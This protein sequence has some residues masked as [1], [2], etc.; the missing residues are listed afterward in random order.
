M[1]PPGGRGIGVRRRGARVGRP[2][3]R[4]VLRPVG[5]VLRGRQNFRPRRRVRLAR[6]RRR[7]GGRGGGYAGTALTAVALPSPHVLNVGLSAEPWPLGSYQFADSEL[8]LSFDPGR[9]TAE[10]LAS[11][12]LP[13]S[14]DGGAGGGDLRGAM[15]RRFAGYFRDSVGGG[16]FDVRGVDLHGGKISGGGTAAATAGSSTTPPLLRGGG[17]RRR[18]G[19]GEDA[20]VA[21]TYSYTTRGMYHPPPREELG[22]IVSDSIN[23]DPV[24]I[25]K[26][27]GDR[28]GGEGEDDGDGPPMPPVFA[29]AESAVS[30]HLTM[31][32]PPLPA[33][34]E[35]EVGS[36][37]E[38]WA[39][40]PIILISASIASLVGL[41]LFRRMLGRRRRA[42]TV[43]DDPFDPFESYFDKGAG[44]AAFAAP[45]RD[46]VY[47]KG[48]AARGKRD[49]YDGGGGEPQG[50]RKNNPKMDGARSLNS[51]ER[52]SSSSSTSG[53]LKSKKKRRLQGGGGEDDVVADITAPPTAAP[54]PPRLPDAP[55]AAQRYQ[56]QLAWEA[57]VDRGQVQPGVRPR[58]SVRDRSRLPKDGGRSGGGGPSSSSSSRRLGGGGVADR[59]HGPDASSTRRSRRLEAE[60]S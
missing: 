8:T 23:A 7:I 47:D 2:R 25:V 35:Y 40:I 45:S 33:I 19:L 36:M 13:G 4:G 58:R 20:V 11:I 12:L 10:D 44:F 9:V 30:R 15:E 41:L 57:Q 32:R 55:T 56:L 6:V 29:E 16:G 48:G 38:G 1:R 34:V 21:V 24:G 18:R 14:D 52:S 17:R 46:D 49:R 42:G 53:S 60:L 5:R 54:P 28:G 59:S 43:H 51:N 50:T 31:K 27:L 26:S 3:P 22:E 37:V 39:T